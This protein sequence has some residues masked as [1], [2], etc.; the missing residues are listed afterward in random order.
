[1][2]KDTQNQDLHDVAR[3]FG[4]F[5]T[6]L[7]LALVLVPLALLIWGYNRSYRQCVILENGLNLG[8]EAVFDLSKPT[9]RPI[10][11]PRFPDGTPLLRDPLWGLYV[12][13]TTVYGVT[14]GVKDGDY[15]FAWRA[16]TG[17]ILRTEN[18]ALYQALVA[19]A[20]QANRDLGLGS[21]GTEVLLNHLRQRPGY[22]SRWCP[23]ELFTW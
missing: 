2:T 6:L 1:M 15:R 12:T 9:L 16:D 8:Y 11:V 18:D 5:F 7:A 19:E 23:T 13:D 21:F 14:Y 10:A 3:A 4:G 17:L 20:G 22:Q